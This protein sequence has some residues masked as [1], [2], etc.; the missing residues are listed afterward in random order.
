MSNP[1]PALCQLGDRVALT[2]AKPMCIFISL[3]REFVYRLG[4]GIV[5]L[6]LTAS[7]INFAFYARKR[8]SIPLLPSNLTRPS[9]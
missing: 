6:V 3:Y 7:A 8:G 5:Q 4:H 9:G 2:L 1:L